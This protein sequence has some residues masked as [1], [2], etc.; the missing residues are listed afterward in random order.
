L[1]QKITEKNPRHIQALHLSDLHFGISGQKI[2]WPTIRSVF[3]EDIRKMHR[4]CGDWQLVLFSGDLTQMGS[5]QEFK[6]LTEA[7]RDIWQL[8]EQ[9]GFSPS[10]FVI[11][12][13]HD[14][15]RPPKLDPAATVLQQWGLR[16]D[17]RKLFWETKDNAYRLLVTSA[18]SNYTKWL[19]ELSQSGIPMLTSTHGSM[20]GDV[21]SV[22]VGNG[23]NLGLVGLNSTWLQLGD[24]DYCGKL[25]IDPGQLMELTNHDPDGWS[26]KNDFNLIVTHHPF[27][28]LSETSKASWLSEI[29]TRTRFD[30]HV[31]GHM[32][33]LNVE[34]RTVGGAQEKRKFQSA[35]LFGLEKYGSEA[36]SRRHGYSLLRLSRSSG[37]NIRIWPRRAHL[38][39]DGA[40]KL[41]PDF[42]FHLDD[43]EE[44]VNYE[45]SRSNTPPIISSPK[46]LPAL[47]LIGSSSISLN[48]IKKDHP[49]NPAFSEVRKVEQAIALSEF[50]SDRP[51]WIVSD[52][53]LG[54]IDFIR[55]LQEKQPADTKLFQL[56][57][58]GCKAREEIFSKVEEQLGFPFQQLGQYLY[59]EG[60]AI[61]VFDDALVGQHANNTVAPQLEAD[62]RQII[63]TLNRFAKAIKVIVTSKLEPVHPQMSVIKLKALDEVDTSAYISAHPRGGRE[64]ATSRFVTALYRHTDGIPARLDSALQYVQLVGL[65]ELSSINTDISGKQAGEHKTPPGLSE[66][67]GE[68]ENSQDPSVARALQLLKALTMFPSGERFNNIKRF[69][70]VDGFYLQNIQLLVDHA[71]IDTTELNSAGE[72]AN[73]DITPALVV[74]RPVREYLYAN[75]SATELRAL[76]KKAMT[77]YFG[78]NWQ[79]EE[80]KPP[81]S[82]RFDR[83]GQGAWVLNNASLMVMRTV[84]EATEATGGHRLQEVLNLSTSFCA[85][86][87]EGDHFRAAYL[88]C[89]DAC[90]LIEEANKRDNE[91]LDLSLLK[92][93][94]AKF[95]R[96]VREPE[97]SKSIL[98]ELTPTLKSKSFK[99]SAFLTLALCNERLSEKDEATQAARECIKLNSKNNLAL[100]AQAVILHND[101]NIENKEEKLKVLELL[102]RKKKANIVANN[103]ALGRAERLT[104]IGDAKKIAL[105]VAGGAEKA[106][107]YYNAIRAHILIAKGTIKEQKPIDSTATSKLIGAYHY[108][109]SQRLDSLFDDCHAVLWSAFETSGDT[110]NLLKL[111]RHSS[112]MWHLRGDAHKEDA[113]LAKLRIRCGT[114]I[115]AGFRNVDVEMAYFLTRALQMVGHQLG[116][117]ASPGS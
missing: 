13:N 14:L 63:I 116:S 91:N 97:K 40:W 106:G 87:E 72:L 48:S 20:P 110:A 89:E 4:K 71:L 94:W 90:P 109:Y 25:H 44:S 104:D 15:Q 68:L 61:L 66:T 60:R 88:F 57:V 114:A 107:D 74:R 75:L 36:M 11:P 5:A 43:D 69:N 3:Y 49:L 38:L 53:G 86:L 42:D 80:I 37:K 111:F 52:W 31:F 30:A 27:S 64:T 54:T 28:W 103:I 113:Y 34:T 9:L 101:P 105:V 35:S 47:E 46:N 12:G 115:E 7:L 112:F 70:G 19:D 83:P 117:D 98:V 108:L 26:E 92:L 84:R 82:L 59:V 29:D 76:N 51:I 24:G 21:S 78:K 85:S 55:W 99:Q 77:L 2:L 65:S 8:F 16:E 22:L 23:I 96:M 45:I 102:A 79:T 6:E 56:D 67:I 18:F 1:N 58:H 32:H 93:Q 39:A 50:N 17:L 100:Q 81:P 33:E 73:Q 95:A 41:I 62:L 10:L